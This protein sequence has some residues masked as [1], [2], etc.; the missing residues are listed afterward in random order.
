MSKHMSMEIGDIDLDI[1]HSKKIPATLINHTYNTVD[2]ISVDVVSMKL[3]SG[4]EYVKLKTN[5]ARISG[6]PKLMLPNQR[7]DII[8]TITIP[9]DYSE[10]ISEKGKKRLISPTFDFVVKCRE[11][12]RSQ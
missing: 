9:K 2:N 12:I 11:M 10:T 4:K 1:G 7:K 6:V 3:K 8:L 5:Y